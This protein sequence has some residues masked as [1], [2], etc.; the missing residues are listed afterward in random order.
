MQERIEINGK[1]IILIGT[2]H[3]SPESVKEVRETIERENPDTVGVELCDRRYEILTKKKQWEEQEIVK[4]IKEGKTYLFLANLLLSNFQKKIGEELG[5]EPGAEMIE[6]IKIAK[7]YEIPVSL[8]DRDISIT[9]KRAWNAMGVK[10]KLKLIYALIAGFFVEAEEVIEELKNQDIIT[11]LMEE[12]AEQAPG[13]K[14]VLIDERD[15]Y[16]ASKISESEGK[17][18]AVVGAGHMEGIKNLLQHRKV[19]REGLDTIPPVRNWFRY[20]KYAIP[21]VFAAIVVYAFLSAGVEMTLHILWIWFLINGS[22]SALGVLLALGHPLS[23]VCA[24]LA[25]PFTSLN[26]ALAA[27][28]FAGLVEAYVRKPKVADFEALRDMGG[29]K[30]FYKNRVTHVLLVIAFANVGSTVG[31]LWA[32]PYILNMLG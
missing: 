15:Q 16:I 30:D 4:I 6:A 12:L 19:S 23:I 9:L 13:A 18:V 7:E 11:E 25:A 32:L 26:P 27:G 3:V 22:L 1:E 8:L 17:M 10:E 24:F 14:R 29:I 31:T 5:S 20:A 21:A 2:V 28:W